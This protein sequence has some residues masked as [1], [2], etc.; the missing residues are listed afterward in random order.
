MDREFLQARID[1]TKAQ[2]IEYEN[3][4]LQISSGAFQSY[5]L[6]TGQTTQTVT[7]FDLNRLQSTIDS[8]YNRL[9]TLEARVSGCGVVTAGPAW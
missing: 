9:A 7:R 1:A 5:N 6:N 4:V 3:A 8:L 2:I